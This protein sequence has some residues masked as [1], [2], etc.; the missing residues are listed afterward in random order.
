MVLLALVM[1]I[2]ARRSHIAI[3]FLSFLAYTAAW[4]YLFYPAIHISSIQM[5]IS[6]F[7]LL[8]LA[9]L[10]FSKNPIYI[11][12][13]KNKPFKIHTLHGGFPFSKVILV[14]AGLIIVVPFLSQIIFSPFFI[15]RSY[16][17]RIPVEKVE[18]S[19]IPG[20]DFKQTAIIDRKS[21]VLLGDKVM[22]RMTDLVS[23]F[24]VSPEYS[25]IS[26]Q[27]QTARVTPLQYDGFIKYLKNRGSGIP[28]Y[29]IVSST[30][31]Q[32]EL[33][34][35]KNKMH[36][37]PGGYLNENIYRKL[38]FQHPFSLF[39]NPS[40]EIDEKGDPYYVCTTY[41]YTG[42][43]SKKRVTGVII[44]DPVKGTSKRYGLKDVPNWVD[45]IYPADLVIQ[46]LNDYGKYQK[47]FINSIIGQE[48]VI[49]TSEGYNY[50]AKDDDIWLYTGM[51]SA[52]GDD[53]NVG[54]VLVDLR[55]HEACLTMTPGATETAVMDSAEGEVL[56][57]GY[58]ATFPTLINLNGSP[59]YLLSLKDSAGL[60]KMYSIVDAEDYQ[61]VYT[62]KAQKD[63]AR[64]IS[65][66][67]SKVTGEPEGVLD[68]VP[69]NID[70]D[71]SDKAYDSDADKADDTGD[72]DGNANS[73]SSSDPFINYDPALLTAKSFMARD[74]RQSV[75][76]GNTYVFIKSDENLYKAKVTLDNADRTLYIASGSSVDADCVPADDGSFLIINIR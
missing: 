1:I 18:F 16:S 21:A 26:Y 70:S 38:C 69:D 64:A 22:G 3:K 35:L 25:Q 72:N 9:G 32:T 20:Y 42:I 46:E 8:V 23:Q 58:K 34:R 12:H 14:L 68:T 75:I 53:S 6:I 63:T 40:F 62:V 52:S 43:F 24:K 5:W 54:F 30:S 44:F 51:T 67:L 13:G 74:V 4:Y 56:N 27:G 17:K 10:V 59:M 15:S 76:N 66:L 65:T 39:E 19:E 36:Y 29:I 57:Y 37:V 71:S 60:V 31:G 11:E 48:G 41:G 45:R 2:F 55:T 49:K 28:G 61:Q 33:V 50:L 7:I 47:G 73:S